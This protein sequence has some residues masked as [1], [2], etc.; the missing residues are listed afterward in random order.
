M[1]RI[2]VVDD[3]EFARMRCRRLLAEN[4]HE[5]DEAENG[6]QAVEKYESFRPDL[7]MMDITMPIL[8]GLGALREIKR[9]DP[10]ARIIMCSALGQQAMVM[11][12]IK[13]GARDFIVKP[14]QPDKILAAISKQVG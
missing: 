3:A 8:D 5:V 9:R 13:A 14:Y 11:E 10:Q 7:V 12:A 6:Q 4:G 2:L 1:A